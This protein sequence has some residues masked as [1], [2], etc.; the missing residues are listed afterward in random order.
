MENWQLFLKKWSGHIILV[1][2]VLIVFIY[3][4]RDQKRQLRHGH[5]PDRLDKDGNGDL[6]Y[7]GRGSEQDD[8]KTLLHRTYWS[9]YLKKRTE[10]WERAF[11]ITLFTTIM[12]VLVVWR[13]LPSAPKIAMTAVV[14][15]FVAYM[16][17]NFLYVHGDI[18]N[19]YNIRQNMRLAVK[20]VD[21]YVD[22]DSNPSPPLIDPPDRTEVM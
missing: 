6:F 5:D 11:L 3:V 14:V 19:D 10:K 4:R 8:L 17:D 7:F 12:L 21:R 1:I 2:V 16:L 18:Y 13:K 22:L 20:K 15:F 9:A